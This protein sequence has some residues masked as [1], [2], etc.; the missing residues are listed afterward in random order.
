MNYLQHP[1][2]ASLIT[3][4]VSYAPGRRR[5]LTY[6]FQVASHSLSYTSEHIF[7]AIW[8]LPRDAVRKLGRAV[9]R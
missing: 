8:F 1:T 4:N 9:M 2:V 6:L 5:L 3:A 7:D